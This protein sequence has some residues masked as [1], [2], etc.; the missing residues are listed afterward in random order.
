MR[1]VVRDLTKQVY[2]Y[3]KCLLCPQI[4]QLGI[5]HFQVQHISE[6]FSHSVFPASSGSML[7]S[8]LESSSSSSV[9]CLCPVN[10]PA[11]RRGLAVPLPAPLHPHPV[12][13]Y[14]TP[15][16]RGSDRPPPQNACLRPALDLDS[17]TTI[18]STNRLPFVFVLSRDCLDSVLT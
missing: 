3:H 13:R 6:I 4:V 1:F 18:V 9:T 8:I 14:G 10:P 7:S 16:A 17:Q 11:G 5:F 2:Y 12:S 15:I